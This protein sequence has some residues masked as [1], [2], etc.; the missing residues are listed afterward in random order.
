MSF[1]PVP[2]YSFREITEISPGFLGNLGINFLMLDL[3]N[4]IAAY[5]EHS[6]AQNVMLWVSEMKSCGIK[7]LIVSNSRRKE[8]VENFAESL[9]IGYINAARKPSP[10]HVLRAMENEGFKKAESALLGDQLYTDMLAAN[11][12]GIVSIT[13]RPRSLKNPFLALR[14][15]LESPFRAVARL[16]RWIDILRIGT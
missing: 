12:A 3:D 14:Y 5:S 9:D 16:S 13:V 1:S 10:K 11:L 8:R 2:R 7:M 4:T 15:A 6:P